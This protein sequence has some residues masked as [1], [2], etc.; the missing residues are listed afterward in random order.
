MA[1][2]REAS[3]VWRLWRPVDGKSVPD[4]PATLQG[5]AQNPGIVVTSANGAAPRARSV[6][7]VGTYRG[8]TTMVAR[9]IEALGAFLGGAAAGV[10]RE[11]PEWARLLA[12]RW[13]RWR[14]VSELASSRSAA[15]PL[16]GLKFPGAVRHLP[17]LLRLMPE[18]RLVVV[19]RDP[20]AVAVREHLSMGTAGASALDHAVAQ[21][22]QLARSLRKTQTPWLAVSYEKGRSAPSTLATAL[23]DL[24]HGER[25]QAL[26][27]RAAAEVETVPI[28]YLRASRRCRVEGHLDGVAGGGVFGWVRPGDHRA[29]RLGVEVRLDGRHLARAVADLHRPDLEERGVGDGRFGF[30][31][32]LPSTPDVVGEHLVSAVAS[33]PAEELRGSPSAIHFDGAEWTVTS[34]SP[35]SRGE[36][37]DL[38][39][40][41][42]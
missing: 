17:R 31:V 26:I 41:S 18:P 14:S 10:V 13:P 16:W 24:L 42:S 20:L 11:D 29:G 25:N 2:S 32:A 30:W 23:C 22:R 21:L 28:S 3:P 36:G 39:D 27:A 12:P 37:P 7:V 35:G 1:A 15:H 40:E 9:M 34:A 8:G 4:D 38:A 6:V 19:F 33:E 5:A